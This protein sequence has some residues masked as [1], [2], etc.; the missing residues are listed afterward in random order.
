DGVEAVDAIAPFPVVPPPVAPPAVVPPPVVS[1]PV[2]HTRAL[3]PT[4]GHV[5]VVRSHRHLVARVPLSCPAAETTGCRITV[6]ITTHGTARGGRAR[7]TVV[8][9]R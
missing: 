1:P 4:L 3:L 7:A 9:G 5:A 8:I 6:T 2:A